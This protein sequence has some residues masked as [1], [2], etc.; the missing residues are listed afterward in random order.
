MGRVPSALTEVKVRL[1]DA[2]NAEEDA[3]VRG[4]IRRKSSYTLG[5]EWVN[6]GDEIDC[7]ACQG[8]INGE[9][10]SIML[11]AAYAVVFCRTCA[12]ELKDDFAYT[13]G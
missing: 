6:D 1:S 3:L 5:I 12:I 2:R 9:A 4:E 7:D 11:P 10:Y 13:I 8:S